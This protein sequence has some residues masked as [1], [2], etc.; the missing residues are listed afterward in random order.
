[1]LVLLPY[2]TQLLKLAA[3]DIKEQNL[4]IENNLLPLILKNCP[5]FEDRE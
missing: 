3:F 5:E 1:L 2:H 4:K